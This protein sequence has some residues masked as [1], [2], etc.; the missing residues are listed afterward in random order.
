MPTEATYPLAEVGQLLGSGSREVPFDAEVSED[1]RSGAVPVNQPM[2]PL[3]SFRPLRSFRPRR[4]VRFAK[5]LIGRKFDIGASS[6]RRLESR[7][8]RGARVSGVC[9]S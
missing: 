4:R 8:S 7:L 1:C 5:A 2:P 9:L 6:H 3:S